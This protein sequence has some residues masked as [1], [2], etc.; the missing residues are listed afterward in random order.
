MGTRA[1]TIVGVDLISVAKL[2]R[3][4]RH[5]VAVGLPAL[6]LFLWLHAQSTGSIS[7]TVTDPT[8]SAAR[9]AK[10]PVVAPATGLSRSAV[11]DDRGEYVVPALGV[12]VYD[13]RVDQ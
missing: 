10:V 7:G 5:S 3:L 2:L 13:V 8:N 11:T 12:G 6:L 4:V 9:G 1:L